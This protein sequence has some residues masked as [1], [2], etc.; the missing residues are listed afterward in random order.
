MNMFYDRRD[1]LSWY[2]TTQLHTTD[3]VIP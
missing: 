3:S 2:T 1:N